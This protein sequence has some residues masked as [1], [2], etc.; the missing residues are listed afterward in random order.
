[1][2][3]ALLLGNVDDSVVGS[4]RA[5]PDSTRPSYRTLETLRLLAG[6]SGKA[7]VL[8]PAGGAARGGHERR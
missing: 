8:Q 2:D 6:A 3:R 5:R 4:G 7:W 1:M